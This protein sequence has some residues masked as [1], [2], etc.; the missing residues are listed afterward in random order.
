MDHSRQQVHSIMRHAAE[1]TGADLEAMYTQIAWPLYKV[2]G[3]A[4][5]AFKVMVQDPEAVFAKLVEVRRRPAC[6]RPSH[7]AF[8]RPVPPINPH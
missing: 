1:T 8:S 5:D 6:A 2:Y 3:H 4:F 7:P